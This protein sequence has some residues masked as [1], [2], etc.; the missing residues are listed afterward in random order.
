M[1]KNIWSPFD[2]PPPSNGDQIFSITRK[3]G[4]V[5]CFWKALNKLR[6]FQKYD[7][8]PFCGDQKFWSPQ[9]LA[10]EKI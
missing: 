8:F 3:G 9:G 10:I 7:T 2:I 6:A 5:I 4:P 1:T